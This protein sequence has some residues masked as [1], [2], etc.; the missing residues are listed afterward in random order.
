MPE[1]VS[2]TRR[3][4]G[5]FVTTVQVNGTR[6]FVYGRGEAEVRRK[7]KELRHQAVTAGTLLRVLTWKTRHYRHYRHC[8][9]IVG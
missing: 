9:P 1:R 8:M 4:D 6:R 2:V 7:V 3:T 5:R